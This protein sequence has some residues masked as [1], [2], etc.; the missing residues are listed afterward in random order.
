VGA[1]HATSSSHSE[2]RRAHPAREILDH[3]LLHRV[4]RSV[5]QFAF[6]QHAFR[7][8]VTDGDINEPC[9]DCLEV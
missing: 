8:G 9:A 1:E 6:D 5:G 4:Q 7:S 2:Q 3:P